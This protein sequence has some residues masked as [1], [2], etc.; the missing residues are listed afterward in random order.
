MIRL[1]I[2]PEK[3]T[4]SWNWVG[5]DTQRELSNYYNVLTFTSYEKM[6]E[7]ECVLAIKHPWKLRNTQDLIKAKGQRAIVYCPIDYFG[8]N[9][10]IRQESSFLSVCDA[11]CFHSERLIPYFLKINKNLHFVEH[12]NKYMLEKP[13]KYKKYGYV[14]WVGGFQYVPFLIQAL[15]RCKLKYEVKI[16][17]DPKNGRAL[18]AARQVAN[19]INVHMTYS[20]N[21][22]TVN[23][24]KCYEWNERIQQEMM[25][26][27]KAAI[28]IKYTNDFNQNTKPPTKAQKFVSSGIPFSINKNSY[29]FE[30][31]QK[32]N[33]SLAEPVNQ[34]RW[35]S[36][37]YH[38]ETIKFAS[39]LRQET[40]IEVVGRKF[41]EI[42][43]AAVS[44]KKDK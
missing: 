27:C 9:D 28:D 15:N 39:M 3:D 8:S 12:N 4:P 10:H 32:R 1:A 18:Q 29:S 34:E 25:E 2:G 35:F 43:D 41:K 5:F 11:L 19:Q 13:N 17:S 22:N 38:S 14:L 37:E 30:Y 16:L 24:L 26:E 7:C 33:F 31:F 40:S 23:G 6:P 36:E 21:L 20:P 42:I 44:N